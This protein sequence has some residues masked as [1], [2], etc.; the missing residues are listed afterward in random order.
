[1][2]LRKIATFLFF[3]SSSNLWSSPIFPE[4]LIGEYWGNVEKTFLKWG[5]FIKTGY[6]SLF[7]HENLV[8][9]SYGRW[10]GKKLND[11]QINSMFYQIAPRQI[12][13]PRDDGHQ[14]VWVSFSLTTF[15]DKNGND[16]D[17]SQ[18]NLFYMHH[19]TTVF[20]EI[21]LIDDKLSAMRITRNHE[22]NI[23]YYQL[24]L[25][26]LKKKGDTNTDVNASP[27]WDFEKQKN[28]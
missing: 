12:S 4:Y 18:S 11:N 14:E 26:H 6:F 8:L 13:V 9:I 21:K 16:F 27:G 3:I 19:M 24:E 7:I 28:Q 25:N 23:P 20:F 5:T 1:M 17:G 22:N 2:K 10:L 15:T